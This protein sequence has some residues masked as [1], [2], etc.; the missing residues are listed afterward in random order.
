MSRYSD[1]DGK[2]D[3]E[4]LENGLSDKIPLSQCSPGVRAR[5]A[6]ARKRRRTALAKQEVYY[7]PTAVTLPKLKFLEGKE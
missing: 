6:S 3:I 2:T 5:C 4:A 1:I 7:T